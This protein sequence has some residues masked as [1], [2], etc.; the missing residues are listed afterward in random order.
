MLA[1]S[2]VP[3]ASLIRAVLNTSWRATPDTLTIT[4][5]SLDTVAPDLLD[6]GAGRL[7]W[8][9]IQHTPLASAASAAQFHATFRYGVLKAALQ[10][11]EIIEAFDLFRSAGVEPILVKGWAVARS[12]PQ[13]ALR[14]SSDLDL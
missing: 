14:P 1:R 4:A 8:H 9:R 6:S 3:V 12:Y 11:Q 13:P 5:E 7:A 2:R 10:E